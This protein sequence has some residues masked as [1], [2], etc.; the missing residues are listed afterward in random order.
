MTVTDTRMERILRRA[1]WSLERL[2]A[3]ATD[4]SDH[5]AR[6]FPGWISRDALEHVSPSWCRRPGS[7][8][9]GSPSDRSVVAKFSDLANDRSTR[10]WRTPRHSRL[11]LIN[12]ARIGAHAA[13]G[14][15]AARRRESLALL[16]AVSEIL[17]VGV[18]AIGE[19]DAARLPAELARSI[20][21]LEGDGLS[22]WRNEQF[23]TSIATSNVGVIFLGGA[24][25]EEEVFIAA[26]EAVRLGYDVR[27]LADLSVARSEA[28]RSLVLDRLA[29]HGVLA[30]TVRQ[31]L[32]EWAVCL[33][34][35]QFHPKGHQAPVVT[36]LSPAGARRSL[37]PAVS[38]SGLQ[39][40]G[41]GLARCHRHRSSHCRKNKLTAARQTPNGWTI[42]CDQ[43]RTYI[44]QVTSPDGAV[45]AAALSK[46]WCLYRIYNGLYQLIQGKSWGLSGCGPAMA[47]RRTT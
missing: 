16:P 13:S 32:L 38:T 2:A 12:P 41:S 40:G 27:L 7:Q 20:T 10:C 11:V 26:L 31:A 33:E 36:E 3:S 15:F 44:E 28:D 30:T 24:F 6:R 19:Y 45:V 1:G 34:D 43:S 18:H 21:S 39:Q 29:L 9:S 4:R 47:S 23:K 25:L 17:G 42:A 22:L 46:K 14:E 35:P 37:P 5:G 8:P